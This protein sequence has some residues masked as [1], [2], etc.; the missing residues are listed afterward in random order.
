M[1]NSTDM[2]SRDAWQRFSADHFWF[3]I[4]LVGI[5]HAP[6]FTL[7]KSTYFRI[8]VELISQAASTWVT[9]F[10]RSC[11][12]RTLPTTPERVFSFQSEALRRWQSDSAIQIWPWCEPLFPM[13]LRLSF[14]RNVELERKWLSARR[15]LRCNYVTQLLIITVFMN[16][17][18]TRVNQK[19]KM[20]AFKV[21]GH[22]VWQV[23]AVSR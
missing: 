9:L 7:C 4:C 23:T 3:P 8:L 12:M 2:L 13:V 22:V 10:L 15:F 5:A 17:F 19:S 20:R 11:S 1:R 18:A 16:V 14:S 6:A 21:C